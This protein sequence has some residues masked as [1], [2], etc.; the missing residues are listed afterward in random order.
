MNLFL[1]PLLELTIVLPGALICL[2]PLRSALRYGGKRTSAIVLPLLSL[3]CLGGA[4][5][6]LCFSIASNLLVYPALLLF[7]L[8]YCQVVEQPLWRALSILL[9]VYGVFSIFGM[10]S[11]AADSFFRP[12]N[13]LPWISFEAGL[14]YNLLCWVFVLLCWYPA[15]RKL[16]WLLE[17][18]YLA[19]FWYIFIVLPLIFIGLNF[20]MIPKDYA[21]IRYGRPLLA[22]VCIELILLMI[23]LLSYLMFFK[24]AKGIERNINLQR[25]NQFLQMQS[26]QYESLRST[27][28]E[29]RQARH[30]LRHHINALSALADREDWT[31]LRSYLRQAGSAIPK[32]E[33]KLCDNSVVDS[34]LG[35]YAAIC[36]RDSIAFDCRALIP[37]ELPV[38]EMELC[39]VLSN[40]LENAVE[41]S[42]KIEP[43]KRFIKVLLEMHGER[44]IVVSVENYAAPPKQEEGIFRS[45][46]RPGPGVGL[47]SVK[48]IAEKNGGHCQFLY[49][50]HI[51]HANIMLRGE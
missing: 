16:P 12:V 14:I 35:Y 26:V 49:S 32:T 51:F 15:S 29:T 5:L 17:G 3:F 18:G 37:G 9:G 42:Y 11:I 43:E 46:K 47:Q 25:E 19:Q 30:D 31:T 40:L 38:G 45:S 2:M 34:V 44:I 1:R 23:L 24:L 41:A 20:F 36:R 22:F 28:A 50:E 7:C 39:M 33:L 6:C 10:L 13:D 27:I 21:N 8:L 48:R 4:G